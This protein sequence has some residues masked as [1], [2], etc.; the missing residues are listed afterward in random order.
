[1][2]ELSLSEIDDDGH[3]GTFRAIWSFV[4]GFL[5]QG[6]YIGEVWPSGASQ[7][8]HTLAGHGPS[9]GRT[10]V[11][12]G[13]LGPPPQVLFGLPEASRCYMFGGKDFP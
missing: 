2:S 6:E 5:R 7:G 10:L 8:H 11:G 9:P 3:D 1:M 13:L 12:C 4:L